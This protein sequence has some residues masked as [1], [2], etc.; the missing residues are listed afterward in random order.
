M[1]MAGL[2]PV[3]TS[4]AGAVRTGFVRR[5]VPALAGWIEAARYATPLRP[6]LAHGIAS[7]S[8]NVDRLTLV[9]LGLITSHRDPDHLP[10]LGVHRQDLHDPLGRWFVRGPP[11][12]GLPPNSVFGSAAFVTVKVTFARVQH[13]THDHHFLSLAAP[14]LGP[15][16]GVAGIGHGS[17]LAATRGTP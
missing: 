7:S 14:V 1:R 11:S 3:A 16:A 12:A 8:E 9:H 6:L 10:A 15:F 17:N 4:R 5:R 13:Q 2:S